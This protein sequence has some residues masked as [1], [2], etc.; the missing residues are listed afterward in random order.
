MEIT[1]LWKILGSIGLVGTIV[2][3]GLTVPPTADEK[4]QMARAQFTKEH[5]VCKVLSGSANDLMGRGGYPS[6]QLNIV[7]GGKKTTVALNCGI[8]SCTEEPNYRR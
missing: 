8:F 1:P 7:C 4:L 6:V 3:L 5:P 2:I